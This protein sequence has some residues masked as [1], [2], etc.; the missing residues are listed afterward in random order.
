M[1]QRRV[2]YEYALEEYQEKKTKMKEYPATTPE[3]REDI[4][5]ELEFAKEQ[6]NEC[7]DSLRK[8]NLVKEYYELFPESN[9]RT[10]QR[11]FKEINS[12]PS[13]H[14]YYDKRLKSHIYYVHDKEDD[15]T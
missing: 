13:F 8:F 15:Y 2:S 10:R 4:M 14:L 3:E 9:E 6:V 1:N 11:D 5:E 12:I 7:V